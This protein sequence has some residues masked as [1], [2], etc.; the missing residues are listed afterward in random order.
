[1]NTNKFYF[2]ISCV[3]STYKAITDMVD[4]SREIT[5]QTFFKHVDWREVTEMFGYDYHPAK[6][7]TLKNDWHIGYYKSVYQG[8][9]CYYLKH[10]AIEYIFVN[11]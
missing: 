1:M 11:E 9:P 3:Q 2:L 4:R 6:G 7:L 10:S 8:K 5:Y